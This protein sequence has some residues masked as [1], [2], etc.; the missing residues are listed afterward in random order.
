MLHQIFHNT[1]FHQ[2]INHHRLSAE[3]DITCCSTRGNSKFYTLGNNIM[4]QYTL[5]NKLESSLA[6]KDLMVLL[7]N[8]LTISQ[9]CT[10]VARKV[11]SIWGCIRKSISSELRDRLLPLSSPLADTTHWVQSPLLCSNQVV[12]DFSLKKQSWASW[13]KSITGP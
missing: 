8:K 6:E 9:Q 3:H 10:P 13:N 2:A 7:D 4:H 11:Y 5:V 12:L 1:A